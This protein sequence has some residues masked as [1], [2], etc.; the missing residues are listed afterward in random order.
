M[1]GS[2]DPIIIFQVYKNVPSA[3]ATLAKIPLTSE[4]KTKALYAIIPIYLSESITGLYIDTESKNYDI[5]TD[6]NSLTS[7][8]GGPVNQKLLASI[9]TVNLF[10]RK[11]SIGLTILLALSELILDKVT[12][13]EYE[14]TYVNGGVTVF[15]G[16]IHSFSYD[17]SANDDL[18]KIKIEFAR[19]RPKTKSVQVAEDPS[20]VRLGSSAGAVPPANAP[21]AAVKPPGGAQISPA[22][23]GRLP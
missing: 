15:G 5:D 21:T 20:A 13:Q 3:E 16:L 17:S 1:L 8:E 14:V 18:Y 4:V 12:S 6:A 10:G 7:G 19:G 11:G 9:T 22:G 2:I 23:I